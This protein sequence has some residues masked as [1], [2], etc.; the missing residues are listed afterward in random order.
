MILDER[1]AEQEN[2]RRRKNPLDTLKDRRL[3][4][5][6]VWSFQYYFRRERKSHCSLY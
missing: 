1:I 3:L 5:P 2:Q 6:Q 4:F